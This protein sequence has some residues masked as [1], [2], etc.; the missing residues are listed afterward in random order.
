[1]AALLGPVITPEGP[2]TGQ[3]AGDPFHPDT[4]HAAK[5]LAQVVEALLRA[6]IGWLYR[7]ALLWVMVDIVSFPH[8]DRPAA[9]T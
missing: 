5:A 3:L 7:L 2:L 8:D 9:L 4:K 6:V 1:M